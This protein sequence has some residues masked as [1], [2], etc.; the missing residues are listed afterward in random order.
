MFEN[1][2]FRS[3]AAAFAAALLAVAA[4]ADSTQKMPAR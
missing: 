2:L 4:H 3:L 1:F